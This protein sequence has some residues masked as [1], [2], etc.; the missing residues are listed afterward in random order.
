MTILSASAG[1]LDDVGVTL[2]RTVTTNLNGTGIRVAHPEGSTTTN[3]PTF[4]VNPAAVGQPVSLFTYYSELGS[5]TNFPNA[6]GNESFSHANFVGMIF[7]GTNGIATNVAHVDNYNA[8]FLISSNIFATPMIA[9]P[10]R[11]VNQSYVFISQEYQTNLPMRISE[12]IEIDSRYDD[13]A[14]TYKTLFVSAAGT[15][16][17][18]TMYAPGTA[19]NS[20]GVGVSDNGLPDAGPTFDNGRSKP[21]ISAP[22]GSTS[23]A[24]PH[25]AGVATLLLQAALRGDAGSDTNAASDMRTIKTLLLNGAIKPASWTNGPATPLDARYG[26][27]VVNALNSYMQLAGGRHAGI[28]QTAVS[29]NAAHPPGPSASNILNWTGWNFQTNLSSTPAQDQI[30]H[31]YFNLT[32]AVSNAS[33]T[34]TATLVWNR[35]LGESNINDLDLCLYDTATSN[36]VAQSI[37]FVNNVEHIHVPH[38]PPGRYDLQVWKAGGNAANGRITGNETYALAWEFFA[39]P[40]GISHD[41]NVTLSWPIYPTGFALESSP[42][43][44]PASWSTNLPAPIVTN[45]SKYI[46]LPA[47]NDARFF[48]LRRP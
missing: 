10:G 14:E 19:Y 48:R 41:T 24:S 42:A 23:A 26:A 5:S 38:L 31:Y 6:I 4:E 12:Q 1:T 46:S 21:D 43:L 27:G 28:E 7:Y 13:Y 22:G 39:L 32:N 17:G 40:L 15:G 36:V 44:S 3:F 18:G 47:T 29:T 33:F 8:D 2:L 16:G 20:I 25:V 34:A 11:I 37:S 30:E 35:Q 9:I 45:G